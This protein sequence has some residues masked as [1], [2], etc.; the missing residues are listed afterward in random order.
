MANLFGKNLQTNVASDTSGMFWTTF[1]DSKHSLKRIV[2]KLHE[3][4]F[5]LAGTPI[6]TL[7]TSPTREVGTAYE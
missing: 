2:L 3:K 7:D 1:R 6:Q 5:D 4:P